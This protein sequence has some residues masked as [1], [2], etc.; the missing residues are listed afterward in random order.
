[1]T[2]LAQVPDS[3]PRGLEAMNRLLAESAPLARRWAPESCWS[4]PATGDSCAWY[5]GAWQTL[6]LLGIVTTLTHHAPLYVEALRPLIAGGQ[7]RRV[8]LS[9]SADYG[10]LS[11]VLDAFSRE[12]AVPEITVVDRCETALK[13]CR[14]YAERFGFSIET[15]P[16][17]LTAF[18]PAEPYDLI[19]VHSLLSCI[20]VEHHAALVE[21][22]R[23]LLRPR[24]RLM[25]ANTLYLDVSD[26]KTRFSPQHV[27]D[28]RKRLFAAAESCRHPE[29]LPPA[30]ELERIAEVF[31]GRMEASVIAS[32][33][34]LTDLMEAGG[35][36]LLETRF[37]DLIDVPGYRRT[38]P[39]VTSR[40]EHAWLIAERRG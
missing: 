20:P 14:W 3:G 12:R 21:T 24:G 40:K 34:Q 31:A 7:C 33:R 13:L 22:W 5:H 37:G 9:G 17:D 19:C 29:A 16:C 36:E 6:R 4:D 32:R 10:L 18:R 11:V 15:V 39:P 35:F 27:A 8:F 38:G 28:Y 23:S 1:M 26:S 30:R 2:T 25:M